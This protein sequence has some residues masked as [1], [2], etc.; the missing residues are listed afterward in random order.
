VMVAGRLGGTGNELVGAYQIFRA[1]ETLPNRELVLSAYN[2]I[3]SVAGY[4]KI[5]LEI[6]EEIV[7]LESL[8]GA[9][10]EDLTNG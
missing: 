5:N 7:N 9:N 6:D 1:T 10:T 4:D 2:R 3:L 8:K